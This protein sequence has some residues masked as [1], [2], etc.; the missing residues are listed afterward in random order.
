MRNRLGQHFLT[1][2]RLAEHMVENADVNRRDVV[3]EIG[4]GKGILTEALLKTGARVVAVEKDMA[5]AADLREKFGKNK[6]FVLIEADIRDV[7]KNPIK[8][9][10]VRHSVSNIKVVANIPY[11]LTGQLFRLLVSD[12]KM[13]PRLLALMVQKEVAER[14]VILT[15][16][17]LVRSKTNLLGLS[18]LP[19]M[20]AEIAFRVSRGSF[21]PPPNV[22]SAVLILKR[23]PRS[24]FAM[25]KAELLTKKRYFVLI[26]AAFA[27]KR[28]IALSVLKRGV[29]FENK[30]S[31]FL[32]PKDSPLVFKMCVVPENARAEDISLEQWLCVAKN[33]D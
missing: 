2:R 15:R 16:K 14:I 19:F 27:Q 17:S 5:L 10:F 11:Y 29:F 3:L 25:S 23:R 20:T 12:R 31:P 26:K 13:P 22:D 6:R 21:Q 33:I 28:K 18:I 30:G 32:V 8:Y 7:L 24:L 9:R 4:P 1:N